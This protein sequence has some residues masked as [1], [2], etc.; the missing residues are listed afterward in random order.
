M[1]FI[2]NGLCKLALLSDLCTL[3]IYVYIYNML[4]AY[5]HEA[6]FCSS[7][8]QLIFLYLFDIQILVC[9]K[10]GHFARYHNTILYARITRLCSLDMDCTYYSQINTHTHKGGRT[11][12]SFSV[13]K[14][15]TIFFI[16]TFF[17]LFTCQL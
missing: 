4:R 12:G 15:L 11:T 7:C 10:I 8:I 5:C 16:D 2:C 9:L 13:I 3:Y 17:L 6:A 1:R 14:H